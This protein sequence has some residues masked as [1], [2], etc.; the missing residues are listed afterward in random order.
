[1]FH[2]LV[3][4]KAPRNCLQ[5]PQSYHLRGSHLSCPVVS[6]NHRGLFREGTR[7]VSMTAFPICYECRREFDMAH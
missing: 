6:G 3:G 4:H 7:P 2:S 1:M 5:H